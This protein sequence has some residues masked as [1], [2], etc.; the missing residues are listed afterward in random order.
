M[1]ISTTAPRAPSAWA[2]V[3][4]LALRELAGAAAFRAR[5]WLGKGYP[6]FVF[7]NDRLT[8]GAAAAMRS[9]A[10]WWPQRPLITL[11]VTPQHADPRRFARMLA[12]L[13]GQLYTHWEL[14]LVGEMAPEIARLLADVATDVGH[15]PR[16]GRQSSLRREQIRVLPALRHG[17]LAEQLNH[18]VAQVRGPFV[19]RLGQHDVL[20]PH[21]L[22]FL[23][24]EVVWHPQTALVYADD[25]L[26]DEAGQRSAP[27][28][29]PDW[30]ADLFH[31]SPY[32]GP[33]TLLRRAVVQGIGGYR[34]EHAGA[35]EH[36]LLLR[37]TAHVDPAQIRH[38]AKVL[39]HI[40]Q[41]PVRHQAGKR[42]LAALYA[43][44]SH[45]VED[46][47][48]PGLYRICYPL[49]DRLPLVSI[50]I[51]TRDQPAVLKKCVDS[52]RLKTS[53]PNWELLII[54]NGSI[55]TETHDCLV[56]L[57]RDPRIRVLRDERPFNFS[58][59]NNA[60]ARQARGEVLA[61]LNDDIEVIA[62]DWLTEM[63][64]QALRPDVGAV[65]AKLL[66][67][68]GTVQHAGVFFGIGSV[69]GHGHKRLP[70]NAE[71]Y[72]RRAVAVQSL[73]AVT[74]ACLV[75][76]KSRYEEV[77]GLNETALAVAYNDVDFCLK[78]GAA[79]YRNIYTPYALLYHHESVSR[80]EDDTVEK[81]LRLRQEYLYMREAWDTRLQIDPAYNPNLSPKYDD[82]SLRT[83]RVENYLA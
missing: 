55:Y 34:S 9:Q 3:L 24:R 21:A 61:L 80:G 57:A 14:L 81:K 68:D 76:L 20:T 30:N 10:R 40:E 39:C 29:K 22:F 46:G 33:L 15:A 27:R 41:A 36:D 13:R 4:R 19:A 73:S 65:G 2:A 26:L 52:L 43:G 71:G 25:D 74:G 51:P 16:I 58:A 53:Y 28:F 66:Y 75:T 82:F 69:A 38:V 44:S 77:G 83:K 37:Y 63:V 59:L 78:L 23:A 32:L 7:R 67:P 64:S 17:T 35:E 1:E 56:A 50:L 48:G 6:G 12:A 72:L 31:A 45:A 54:D 18:A 5:G 49:P 60:A 70:G 79:G 11:I 8:A 42:A 62:P 47:A